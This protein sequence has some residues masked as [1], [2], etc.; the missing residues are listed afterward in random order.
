MNNTEKILNKFLYKRIVR[1]R[2]IN[3]FLGDETKTT[4]AVQWL[5][6]SGKAIVIRKGLYYLKH[7]E[8]LYLDNFEIN[9]LI[10]AGNFHTSSAIGYHASLKCYGVAY[11]ESNLFQVALSNSVAR[12]L[13]PFKYQNAEYKFY[14]TDLSYGVT[15]SVIED[16]RV[17]HFSRERIILEGLM[18]PDRFLGMSEFLKS[19]ENFTWIDL[20]SLMD[21]YIKY[22]STT[23]SMRLGWLFENNQKRWH[24][25]ESILKKLERHRPE[26]RI[27]LIKKRT[28]GNY[29][30][31]RWSLMVP[32]TI[33]ELNE[34]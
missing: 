22:P 26:S 6:K 17:K 9:P 8:E 20:D 28:R 23:I 3:S 14:R 21:L 2:E 10:L 12:V 25:S 30:V 11:S 16:V 33:N 24:V 18:Y 32:K 15:S 34:V 4:T 1:W 19:I 29:L 5:L 13:K 7:P 31:K 27:L